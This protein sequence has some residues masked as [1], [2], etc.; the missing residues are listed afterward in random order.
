MSKTV[1]GEFPALPER[2]QIMNA[3]LPTPPFWER[4]K[5]NVT[6][7]IQSPQELMS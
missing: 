3:H 1:L 5:E 6:V 4:P 7:D 2:G